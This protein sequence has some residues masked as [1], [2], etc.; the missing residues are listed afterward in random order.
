MSPSMSKSGRRI[1]VAL[2][3]ALA[4]VVVMVVRH[5]RAAA[6]DDATPERPE[7]QRAFSAP[8]M[9]FP[10]GTTDD[11]LSAPPPPPAGAITGIV[12]SPEG[13]PLPGIT[14]SSL[15]AEPREGTQSG[16][17]GRFLLTHPPAGT[18][19]IEATHPDYP[20]A[21]AAAKPGQ[22]DL[23]LQFK[24]GALIAGT[25]VDPEGRPLVVYTIA[26][27]ETPPGRAAVQQLFEVRGKRDVHDPNGAFEVRGLPSGTLD[28]VAETPDGRNARLAGVQLSDGEQKRGLLLTL[29]PGANVRGRIVDQ[30]G[31]PVAGARTDLVGIG[32]KSMMTGADGAYDLP[33]ARG[34]AATLGIEPGVESGL[35]GDHRKVFIPPGGPDLD[36]GVLTLVK[37][38]TEGVSATG[39]VLGMHLDNDADGRVVVGRVEPGS[40]AAKAGVKADDVIVEVDGV[41]TTSWL[42]S[43]GH[44]MAGPPGK[45]VELTC[46]SGGEARRVTLVR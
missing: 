21:T 17:D 45:R 2:L 26:V 43:V 27:G 46:A 35:L 36:L 31:Q 18:S 29:D 44:A 5:R 10:A 37:G 3:L 14:V 11:R 42:G 34:R 16:K 13:Q 9:P 32:W 22:T 12:L 23:T 7:R 15:P 28:V 33:M 25:V 39:D 4:L 40:P 6:P 20:K 8:G 1:V 19:A 24:R 41:R 30:A 38:D